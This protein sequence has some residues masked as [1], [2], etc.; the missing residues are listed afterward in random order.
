MSTP[1]SVIWRLD[2]HSL[3]K[4][5]ILRR[6]LEAWLPIMTTNFERVV[7]LD[8][9]AGPGEYIG[10]EIGSPL[11][12][13]NVLLK[14]KHELVRKREV[15]FLF[16][17]EDNRRC[18]HLR[19]L[20]AKQELP[21]KTKCYVHQGRFNETLTGLLSSLE[22]QRLRLAPTFA[23]IDPFGFSHTPMSVITRLMSHPRCEFL[24]TFM[25][26]E[27]SRFLS[28]DN[29]AIASH[30]DELFGTQIWRQIVSESVDSKDRAQRIHDLYRDQLRR[31]GARFIRSFCIR[32]KHNSIDY[33]LFF[34]TNNLLGMEK[35]KDA[36]W[37]VDSTGTYVFS[38][39]TNPNQLFLIPPVPDYLPLKRI[40]TEQ[41]KG[42]IVSIKEIEE[43]I[44]AETPFRKSGYKSEVLK[45][46]ELANPPQIKVVSCKAGRK[47][48]QF[49]DPEMLIQFL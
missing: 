5:E 28:Y 38:D 22:E 37:A 29:E 23:F 13:L 26:E 6:Y 42:A 31:S 40:L 9:F 3:A 4:H 39:F 41:Y 33:F 46:M 7:V 2:P 35:M 49:A 21:A 1:K 34:G 47:R 32:N 27:I 8:G 48:G 24:I 10:G 20:L 16:V 14:H 15:V 30:Y 11:I 18:D 45:P 25:H 44:I 43:F 19:S 17:E 12:A 36:M